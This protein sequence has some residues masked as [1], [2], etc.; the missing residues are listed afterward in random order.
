MSVH[1]ILIHGWGEPDIALSRRAQRVQALLQ[2]RDLIPERIN[3]GLKVAH[4]AQD[5]GIAIVVVLL[6]GAQ[7]RR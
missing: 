7:E 3:S 5:C 1:P 4:R 2:G 6:S